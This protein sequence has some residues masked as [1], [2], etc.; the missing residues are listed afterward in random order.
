MIRRL[1]STDI[2]KLKAIYT[3]HGWTRYLEDDAT[4][5]T[6]FKDSLATYVFEEDTIIKGMVRVVGDNTHILYIQD[7][8]VHQSYLRAG[9]GT[10]LIKWLLQHYDHVRQKVLLTD[11]IDARANAFY[12]SLGFKE[13]NDAQLSCYVHFS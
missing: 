1:K 13:A 4:F 5:M 10:A 7:I 11:K 9:I 2:P 6:M 8:L 3:S 12:A